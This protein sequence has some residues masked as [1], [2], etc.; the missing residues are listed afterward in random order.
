MNIER[1]KKPYWS[2]ARATYRSLVTSH[3]LP[4]GDFVDI[5]RIERSDRKALISR[6]ATYGPIF[7]GISEN[8]VAVCV[9]GNEIGQRLLSKHSDVLQPV[10]VQLSSLFSRGFMRQM[11]GPIHR[12]YKMALVHGIQALPMDQLTSKVENIV[13][14]QLK[15][16]SHNSNSNI[17]YQAWWKTLSDISTNMLL[18]L[19]FECLPGDPHYNRLR[20]GFTKLGPHGLVW[21]IKK[22]QAEAYNEL[23]LA[24]REFK[25]SPSAPL[26]HGLID[27][28]R[29]LSLVDD[30]MLGNLIY[31]VEMGRYDL[32]GLLRW[33]S[34]YAGEQP[35]W[36]ARIAE[37]STHTSI[38]QH[39]SASA[40]IHE[41]LRL[42]Q[43]ERL[44]RQVKQNLVFD[45]YLIPKGALLRICMWEAHKDVNFFESPFVFNPE[46]FL[47][48]QSRSRTFLPFGLDH[49]HCPFSSIT[50]ILATIFMQVICRS[51]NVVSD[52]GKFAVRGPYH[53][54]PASDLSISLSPRNRN[55]EIK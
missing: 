9:V 34:K 17:E 50:I 1:F 54:Q 11:D 49:H 37:E 41:V 8:K 20:S 46:R 4:P 33:L 40:F 42:E 16:F 14:S 43:S 7:K 29:R 13:C 52:G 5:D 23:C 26:G 10:T 18:A 44:M 48:D 39:S 30:T 38:S 27:Q 24:I 15:D 3:L 22:Q 36:C 21:N 32:C 51:Y 35:A 25:L 28:I 19:F 2:I 47:G 31:M 45:N 12:N 55:G 53:W 6:A